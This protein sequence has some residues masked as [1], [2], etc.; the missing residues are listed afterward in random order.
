MYLKYRTATFTSTTFV[1]LM[2][3]IQLHASLDVIAK[4]HFNWFENINMCHLQPSA[5]MEEGNIHQNAK[6]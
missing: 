6:L 5:M 3:N 1:F 2:I 4:R